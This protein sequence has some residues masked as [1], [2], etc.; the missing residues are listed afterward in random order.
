[1]EFQRH[2]W[3]KSLGHRGKERWD[4]VVVQLLDHSTK[5]R[6]E[7]TF[8]TDNEQKSGQLLGGQHSICHV[9]RY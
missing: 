9:E 2:A 5:R 7:M 6:Q 4:V 1:M 3:W 8:L